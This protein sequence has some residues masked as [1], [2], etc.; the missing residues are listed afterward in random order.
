MNVSKNVL[1]KI[2][3]KQNLNLNGDQKKL[4]NGCYFELVYLYTATGHKKD[5]IK[6]PSL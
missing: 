1:E 5:S 6:N 4:P 2:K 3:Q